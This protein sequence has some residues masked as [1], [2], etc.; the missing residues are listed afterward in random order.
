MMEGRGSSLF[1][2]EPILWPRALSLAVP[3]KPDP[4]MNPERKDSVILPSHCSWH[5]HLM[6]CRD[7]PPTLDQLTTYMEGLK[8]LR[9]YKSSREGG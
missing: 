3:G 1:T 9:A 7:Q 8:V 5:Q 4:Y 2:G 6:A